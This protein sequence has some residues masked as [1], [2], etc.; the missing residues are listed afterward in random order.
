MYKLLKFVKMSSLMYFLF[1]Y[2]SSINIRLENSA[3]LTARISS[4]SL[5]DL[6]FAMIFV[7]SDEA[8]KA[9]HIPKVPWDM[10]T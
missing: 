4:M 2:W 3:F 5:S 6:T 1:D 8:K 9:A 10:M 7:F